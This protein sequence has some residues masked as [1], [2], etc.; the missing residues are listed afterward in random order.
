MSHAPDLSMPHAGDILGGRYVLVERI[1]AGGMGRV[2][3]ARDEV[4]RRDVAIK[5]FFTDRSDEAESLRRMAEARAL[6]AL[7][8]PSLVTLYDARLDTD[9]HVYLVMELI[10]GP[11]LQRRIEQGALATSEVAAI[12]A[13][14]AAALAVVHGAGIV[15]RDIKPSN[16]LLRPVRGTERGFEA[17]LADFGVAHLV[18]ATRLTTPGTVIGTAAYLAPEQVRGEPPQPA[19]DV[20]ALGLLAIEALTRLHPFGGGS[21]Q[22]TLLARLAR[23]PD[24]PSTLGYEWRSLLSAMTAHEPSARPSASEVA[25]R[26]AALATGGEPLAADTGPLTVADSTGWADLGLEGLG[27]DADA[28]TARMD[29]PG[30]VVPVGVPTAPVAAAAASG[31]TEVTSAQRAPLATSPSRTPDAATLA[32]VEAGEALP[33]ASALDTTLLAAD[34]AARTTARRPPNPRRRR[35]AWAGVGTAAAVVVAGHLVAF[36]FAGAGGTPSTGGAPSPTPSL[37]AETTV[38]SPAATVPDAVVEPVADTSTGD[39]SDDQAPTEP[40]PVEQPPVEIVPLEPAPADPPASVPESGPHTGPGADA[41]GGPG[42]G[43]GNANGGDNAN[44][45]ASGN[46]NGKANGASTGNGG[47][48]AR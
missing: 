11:S 6:A 12:M 34:A 20:Y 16:V 27:A 40:S 31:G 5:I 2:F 3:R 35:R 22:E 24:V 7:A 29:A 33:A 21:V 10:D 4:L 15:H 48:G 17:V 37:M 26:A 38:P 28:P 42:S 19:S 39:V 47:P 18:D 36:S 44:G 9:D 1:G 25:E 23:Q 43:R 41:G 45:N 14:L 32:T 8:H 46:G 30:P 13:D